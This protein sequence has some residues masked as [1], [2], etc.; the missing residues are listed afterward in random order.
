[1]TTCSGRS[2]WP[3]AVTTGLTAAL[4]G[5]AGVLALAA[6][7]RPLP[8]H[9]GLGLVL[10]VALFA[11]A[12]SAYVSVEFRRQTYSF[13]VAGIPLVLGLLTLPVG[14]VVLAR[15]VGAA[16]VLLVQRL[17]MDKLAYNVAA[18]AFETAA[19][20]WLLHPEGQPAEL[21]LTS[22]LR[23][24]GTL[25][26]VD[27]VMTA[28]VVLVIRLHGTSMA[29]ADVATT[30]LPALAFN[31]VSLAYALVAAVLLGQG[32]LGL[33]L[34]VALSLLSGAT[35]R[36]YTRLV[37]RHHS[38]AQV[39]DFVQDESSAETVEELAAQRLARIRALLGAGAARAVL[40]DPASGTVLQLEVDG[41]DLLSV[42]TSGADDV[43][44]LVRMVQDQDEALL[45]GRR[46]R[47]P[48]LR[49]WLTD[50]GV[51]DAVV[52]PLSHGDGTC[53]ALLVVD[54]QADHTTFTDDDLTMLRTLAG[55]L[56]VALRSMRLHERLRHDATHD[57]LTGL[58]NRGLLGER[59]AAAVA[60]KR[61][62]DAA[63]LLLDLDG[64]KEVNDRLG[65]S[66]GD[67]LLQVVGERLVAGAPDGATVA[68]L[69]GDEFAVLLTGP[70]QP[71]GAEAVG[72]RAVALAHELATGLSEPVAVAEHLASVGVSIGVS[73]TADGDSLHD[74]L[75]HADTAMYA[76]KGAGVVVQRYTSALDQGR[77]ARLAL[78]A[79]LRVG[80]GRRRAGA[81]LPAEGRPDKRPGHRRRGPRA[82]A[83]PEAGAAL[84]RHLHPPRRVDR[85][86]AAP[87]PGRARPGAAGLPDLARPGPGPQRGGQ[88]IGERT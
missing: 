83:A 33:V 50:R 74:L 42:W 59:L 32:A 45:L 13:T 86:H 51:R 10:L 12:E 11:V 47:D 65:H 61:G 21:D 24:Y 19:A 37:A 60:G 36:A 70:A 9:A 55:H 57:V 71:D 69:G 49:R 38:L 64:F 16:A 72:E 48:R 54:R 63:V 8:Q 17:S 29:A 26:A 73:T 85:A 76:A 79:D 5:A 40:T 25:L 34:L 2:V 78:I 84:A 56:G 30:L 1:M 67:R 23:M 22:G 43:D 80:I 3:A 52:A 41:E 14:Q 68:R 31:A 27:L 4:A 66:G 39:S 18:F 28:L 58:P 6:P 20:G 82:L 53:G 44:W 35:Y 87:D 15:V 75:R 77:T 7:D 88:P 81:A 46:C 62:Q